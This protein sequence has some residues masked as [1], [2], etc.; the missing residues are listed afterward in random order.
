MNDPSWKKV[1]T[2][3]RTWKSYF[4]GLDVRSCIGDHFRKV[5]PFFCVE[6]NVSNGF[7]SNGTDAKMVS[8]VCEALTRKD[9]NMHEGV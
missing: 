2:F 7:G 6:D 5:N 8:N 4:F 3:F 9:A 1:L